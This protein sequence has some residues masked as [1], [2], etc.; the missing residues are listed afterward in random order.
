MAGAAIIAGRGVR[1]QRLT[2]VPSLDVF[3][4]IRIDRPT[5]DLVDA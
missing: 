5:I 3:N 1:F 4:V 2:M